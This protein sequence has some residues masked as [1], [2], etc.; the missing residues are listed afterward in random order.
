[1]VHDVRAGLERPLEHRV[2]N[3]LSTISNAPAFCAIS[4]GT[5][6]GEPHQGFVGVSTMIARVLDVIASAMRCGSR[7]ST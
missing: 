5:K 6:V 3:V 2:A 4:S 1:V 7:Q